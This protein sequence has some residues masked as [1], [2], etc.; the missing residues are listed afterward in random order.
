MHMRMCVCLCLHL[1]T[2]RSAQ[3]LL[4]ELLGAFL[5]LLY[6]RSGGSLPL[7][8]VTHCTFNTIVVLLRAAQVGSTLPF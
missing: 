3:L 7:V 6:Q 8:V 5:A 1:C 2:C 4:F